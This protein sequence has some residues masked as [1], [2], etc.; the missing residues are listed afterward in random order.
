MSTSIPSDL[1]THKDPTIRSLAAYIQDLVGLAE[2]GLMTVD[3]V[4]ELAD[5][6]ISAAR[7]STLKDKIELDADIEYALRLLAEIV[8]SL[9]PALKLIS[10]D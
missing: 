8:P 1:L 5:D 2:S 6:V 9:T 4:A 3:E 7:I 10:D